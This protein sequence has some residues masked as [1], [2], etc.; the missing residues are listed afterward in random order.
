MNTPRSLPE[1]LQLVMWM[2]WVASITITTTWEV[3]RK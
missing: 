1:S 3:E 2:G